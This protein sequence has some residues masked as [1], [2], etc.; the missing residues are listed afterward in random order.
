MKIMLHHR[1]LAHNLQ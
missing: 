1:Q